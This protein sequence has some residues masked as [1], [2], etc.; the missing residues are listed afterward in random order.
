MIISN[1]MSFYLK[2]YFIRYFVN[3]LLENDTRNVF[4]SWSG[5]LNPELANWWL[6][7]L[8]RVG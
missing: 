2:R 1:A 4:E 5:E 6:A 3:K 8:A 7:R